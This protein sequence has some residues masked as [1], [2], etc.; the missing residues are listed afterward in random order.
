VN[1]IDVVAEKENVKR[2]TTPSWYGDWTAGTR[3]SERDSL[4]SR[5]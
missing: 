3:V 5:Y 4:G 1:G 2:N